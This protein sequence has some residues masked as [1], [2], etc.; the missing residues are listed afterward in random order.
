MSKIKFA[1]ILNECCIITIENKEQYYILVEQLKKRG[2]DCEYKEKTERDAWEWGARDI[3]ILDKV[4]EFCLTKNPN[5]KDFPQ[6]LFKNI[7]FESILEPKPKKK[8]K[9]YTKKNFINAFERHKAYIRY[10]SAQEHQ[11]ILERLLTYPFYLRPYDSSYNKDYQLIGKYKEG[12]D[13]YVYQFTEDEDDSVISYDTFIEWYPDE[14]P[15]PT[16][17]QIERMDGKT[18]SHTKFLQIQ[19]VHEVMDIKYLSRD[20]KH[21][22]KTRVLIETMNH[23]NNVVVYYE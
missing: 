1:D 11:L 6:I 3:F 21:P 13:I 14:D 9:E 20:P 5:Y 7:L 2:F 16:I 22:N 10:T 15:K 8:P 4:Q 17:K 23:Y 12:A 19:N 18:I